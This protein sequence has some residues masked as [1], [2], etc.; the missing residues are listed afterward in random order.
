MSSSKLHPR[1]KNVN[2]YDFKYLLSNYAELT[3]FKTK[4]TDGILTIDF[5]NP[6]CVI[7]FSKVI[8]SEFYN[9]KNWD[10]PKGFLCPPV[11]GR[12]DYIH[13]LAD[14][15][16]KDNKGVIPLEGTTILDIGTGA[17]CIYPIIG[18]STYKW[19]FLG[20]DIEQESLDIAE[21]NVL[22]NSNLKSHIK[23]QLQKDK[24]SIFKGLG[25]KFRFNACVCNPPFYESFE[26]ALKQSERRLKLNV[27]EDKQSLPFQGKNNELWCVGGE[28]QFLSTMVIESSIVP[29][30]CNWFTTLVSK[31]S[32]LPEMYKL[33]K[34]VKAKEV[35]TI[36]MGH[37]YKV[38]RFVAWRF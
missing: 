32:N 25:A 36:E 37:G 10:L 9:V 8:L 38:R 15:L 29:N 1:N 11:P 5:N 14:L 27:F 16:A 21:K 17:N 34:G 24:K 23:L 31:K 7:V 13:F 4:T 20:V 3:P 35:K 12:A 30:L 28:K 19:N 33:L 26:Q 2:G 18:A 22:S 6:D